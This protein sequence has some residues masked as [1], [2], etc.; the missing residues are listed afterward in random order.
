MADSSHGTLRLRAGW[1]ITALAGFAVLA[2]PAVAQTPK[3]GSPRQACRTDYQTL[4]ASVTPGRGRIL[5]C[6]AQHAD[7]L[8]PGCQQALQSAR[9]ATQ[10]RRSGT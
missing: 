4:C 2:M 1:T 7:T 9:A 5:A 3:P 10:S 6:L 8:S